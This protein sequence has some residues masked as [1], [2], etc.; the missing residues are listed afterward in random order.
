MLKQSSSS[1]TTI[2]IKKKKIA[3]APLKKHEE[4]MI[5]SF[6]HKHNTWRPSLPKSNSAYIQSLKRD[7]GNVSKKVT[8]LKTL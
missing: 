7:H 5:L 3:C 1:I 2:L 4:V 8:R 6:E